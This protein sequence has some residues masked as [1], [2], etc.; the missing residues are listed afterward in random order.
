[1]NGTTWPRHQKPPWEPRRDQQ[2][3][4]GLGPAVSR[5]P[6]G[7]EL[8]PRWSQAI[9]LDLSVANGATERVVSDLLHQ[10]FRVLELSVQTPGLDAATLSWTLKAENTDA[11]AA[12]ATITNDGSLVA[13][14][15]E[16]SS[17]SHKA[18]SSLNTAVRVGTVVA[19]V[20][21]RIVLEATNTTAGALRVVAFVSLQYLAPV[22][23]PNDE[24][25]P[26][27]CDCRMY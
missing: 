6:I 5:P 22:D 16:G 18:V 23:H 11:A 7:P 27:D 25:D 21:T 13:G 1:M 17:S 26:A 14:H 3:R 12:A 9:F 15:Q 2:P 4:A 19:D 10:P 8:S 24:G 20:P